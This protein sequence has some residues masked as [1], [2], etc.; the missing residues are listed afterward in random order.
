MAS[1]HSSF[2]ARP[3][4]PPNAADEIDQGV[5]DALD[6]LQS[7]SLTLLQPHNST[8]SQPLDT[9][10]A[11][12][13]ISSQD[14][15]GEG[16]NGIRK[17][18]A[19]RV[20]FSTCTHYHKPPDYSQ[21]N[22]A[23]S[24]LKQL[25][26]SRELKSFRSILKQSSQ[27]PPLSSPDLAHRSTYPLAGHSF[28]SLE[29]MLDFM[30]GQLENGDRK[31][32]FDTYVALCGTLA[33]CE[34]FPDDSD[35][36]TLR[37]QIDKLID[38]VKRDS[39]LTI[40]ENATE[41]T[42]L[43]T[44]SLKLLSILLFTPTLSGVIN[45]DVRIYVVERSIAVLRDPATSKPAVRCYIAMLAQQNFYPTIITPTRAE[46]LLHAL[47]NIDERVKGNSIIG[48]RLSIYQRILT[49]ARS[50]FLSNINGILEHVFHGML[51][52]VGDIRKR[53]I[54]LGTQIGTILGKH[55]QS[56]SALLDL[57]NTVCDSEANLDYGSFYAG[58]LRRMFRN[59]DHRKYVPQIWTVVILLFQNRGHK[60]PKW[61]HAKSWL[62][63]IQLCLNCSDANVRF[64]AFFAWNRFVAVVR[65]DASTSK[66]MVS[67]LAQPIALQLRRTETGKAPA[68][69]KQFALASFCNLLY[70]SF[71]PLASFEELDYFWA[72]Y[73]RE[74]LSD[75]FAQDLD[76][77]EKAN[78]ILAALFTKGDQL[79]WDEGRAH[80]SDP[81]K[82]QELPRLSVKWLRKRISRILPLLE[83][84][85]EKDSRRMV[86]L[87]DMPSHYTWTCLMNAVAEAGSQ[88]V[89]AS[90][91]LREA[92]AQVVNSLHRLWNK[93]FS[94]QDREPSRTESSMALFSSIACL[95]MDRLG[96]F[97]FTQKILVEKHA[98]IFE[99]APSPSNRS[100]R[101][102]KQ[103]Q[104]PFQ[105]IFRLLVSSLSIGTCRES[106]LLGISKLVQLAC[107]SQNTRQAKL[108]I[109]QECMNFHVDLMTEGATIMTLLWSVVVDEMKNVFTCTQVTHSGSHQ[110]PEHELQTAIDIFGSAIRFDKNPSSTS[111]PLFIAL[112][113][114]VR[115]EAGDGAV[116]RAL[117]NP[118]ANV[119]NSCVSS[120]SIDMILSYS[121]LVL[122]HGSGPQ[123]RHSLELGY[124]TI[125]GSPLPDKATQISEPF[126][127]VY[128]LIEQSLQLSHRPDGLACQLSI[129]TFLSSLAAFVHSSPPPSKVVIL[130]RLQKGIAPVV[131]DEEGLFESNENL[132]ESVGPTYTGYNICN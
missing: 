19:K 93:I 53:A 49:Q 17:A 97:H 60:L 13:P 40:C 96:S 101:T 64:Q 119:I 112:V 90:L 71:R 77:A 58:R 48:G 120:M 38:Y 124:Q 11:S 102:A 24:P 23:L 107:A 56:H 55:S 1:S 36:S 4:T 74:Q 78:H 18:T 22:L 116:A 130:Q 59:K 115:R 70:Y 68:Q 131:E 111:Q 105:G 92:I 45:D 95:A 35:A 54:E 9:P 25:P 63:L 129:S 126:E 109:L 76:Y 44:Q 84:S 21:T 91:D 37:R 72:A 10:P 108:E 47:K 12:S 26:P 34:C 62:R 28:E 65:P 69:V 110:L 31:A 113:E 121:S 61:Q 42:G 51:S 104:S 88:E 20:G 118:L 32:K 106:A 67:M 83:K 2:L 86:G 43:I 15:S 122:R 16:R 39:I 99:V 80:K 57:F 89:K 3:P 8:R 98:A 85:L 125:S 127:G 73:I 41:E 33:A 30:L 100:S 14:Q 66:E 7:D 117:I 128:C 81:L 5:A 75:L 94:S 79:P 114:A 103:M 29:E 46:R 27:S 52:S 82:P 132:L 123:N 50:A 6:F 87:E